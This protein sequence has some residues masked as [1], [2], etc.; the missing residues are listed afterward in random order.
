MAE[1]DLSL[2]ISC[3][4]S[5]PGVILGAGP[6][7]DA[8]NSAMVEVAMAAPRPRKG[9]VVVVE[10]RGGVRGVLL[11]GRGVLPGREAGVVAAPGAARGAPGATRGAPGAARGALG[12][13]RGA[14]GA[15]QG[16]PGVTWGLVVGE[17]TCPCI[18]MPGPW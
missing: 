12:A 5:V 13:A 10:V 9:A 11:R 15:A 17:P 18:Q 8:A 4:G 14:L 16:A 2:I 6:R 7:G 1:G 3:A